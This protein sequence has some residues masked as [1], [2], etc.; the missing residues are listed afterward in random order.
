MNMLKKLRRPKI[1]AALS[2][3]DFL[4]DNEIH[5]QKLQ[6]RIAFLQSW[7]EDVLV[8]TDD[9]REED[10]AE[11]LHT[12]MAYSISMLPYFI[13]DDY[14]HEYFLKEVDTEFKILLA[15]RILEYVRSIYPT[16]KNELLEGISNNNSKYTAN[17]IYVES[18]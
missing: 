12:I 18:L 3:N 4:T 6:N 14:G 5:I 10:V 11:E 7:L 8:R 13:L 17:Y 9:E 2:K 1:L 15:T 16:Y